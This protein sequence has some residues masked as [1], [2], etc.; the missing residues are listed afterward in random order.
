[1]RSEGAGVGVAKIP[2]WIIWWLETV[3]VEGMA[4]RGAGLRG[5]EL[6]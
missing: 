4:G 5:R 1:M 3:L 2:F 6:V